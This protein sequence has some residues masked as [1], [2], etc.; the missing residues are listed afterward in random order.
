MEPGQAFRHQLPMRHSFIY[1]R[2]R[3]EIHVL[4]HGDGWVWRYDLNDGSSPSPDHPH[5]GATKG[6]LRTA[7]AAA[8]SVIDRQP[9]PI[10]RG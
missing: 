3:V 7:C 8:R 1:K 5:T 2:H 9:E 10:G 4:K 6:A